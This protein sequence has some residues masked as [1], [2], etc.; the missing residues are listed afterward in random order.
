MTS[1]GSFDYIIVGA[2]S[3]G[4]VLANRL[5]ASGRHRVL[6]LEAGGRDSNPWIHIPLGYGKLFNN[7]E[8]NWKFQSEPQA[9]LGDRIVNLPRGKVLGG[10]SSINGLVYIRGQQ[11]D[12]DHWRELGNRGWSYEDVLPY[13]RKAEDQ[14]RG[15]DSYHGAGGPLPVSDPSEPNDICDA[16]IAAAKAAG[17]PINTD[18]N[19]ATQEG[20]GYFQSTSRRGLRVSSAVAYLEPAKRR[21]NLAVLTKA[22]ATR[23]LFDDNHNVCGVEWLRDG[24]H[25]CATAGG[26]VILAAGAF[27]TPQLLQLSGLG[28]GDLLRER[29][30]VVRKQLRGVGANLQD[31]YQVRLVAGVTKPITFNDDMRNIF[32]MSRVGLRFL[33]RRR[34]PLTISA[35]YAGGFFRTD[36]GLA[37]PD[38]QVH[39]LNFSSSKLGDKLDPFSAFTLSS[40][41]LRPES[42]GTVIIRSADPLEAPLINP[43]Y[44]ATETDRRVTV[45]GVKLLR[46]IVRT[47]PLCALVEM[48]R[49]PG[50]AVSSDEDLLNYCRERGGSIHHASCTARMGSGPD[51]V[52]DEQLRVHGV[53][54]LRI[55][56]GSVMPTIVSGNTHAAIVMIGEKAADLILRSAA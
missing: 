19:G 24:Q 41:Q 46:S 18:F 5:S 9:F 38:I 55:A 15:S 56:D 44:L 22:H 17:H 47:F 27:G 50:V 3:A 51:A 35:G 26:E 2:G 40:C 13:F 28:P 37:T 53:G 8:V 48:E 16:F 45:A 39:L 14:E 29:G 34:G 49:E 33:L 23:L 21:P 4:C 6:L 25:E 10:S 54:R 36:S 52:V 1:I 42:R 20:A 31:H 11:Q 12:F 32:R 30:I 43:N 7:A